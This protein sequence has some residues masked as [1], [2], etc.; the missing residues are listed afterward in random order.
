MEGKGVLFKRFAD[1]DVFDIEIDSTRRRGDDPHLRADRPHLR[2]HQSRG[3]PRA[4]VLRDRAAADR[5]RSTSRS[6][7]TTS[8]ARRSSR[9]RRCSTR[10]RSPGAHRGG[11]RVVF[12][13]RGPRPSPVPSSTATS[14]SSPENMLV[15]RQP[16]RDLRRPRADERVQEASSRARPTRARSAD[17]MRGA[18]VFVGV[19]QAG[20]VDA[21]DGEVDGR[22]ADHLRHGQPGPE[23]LPHEVEAVRP[24]AITGHRALRLPQPGQQRPGLPL[25]L[26]RCPRRGRNRDQRGDEAGGRARRWP[27][28]PAAAKRY[29]PS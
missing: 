22:P 24:D 14:A 23:I 10:S 28:W 18:D 7:T 29:R 2:G 25:H 21:G 11:C 16:R 12:S 6:S 20:V 26:P 3:H 9:G 17:A 13:G 27:S 8:T 15:V 5:E 1:I 19:S 4:R